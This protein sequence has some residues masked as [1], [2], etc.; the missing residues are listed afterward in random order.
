MDHQRGYHD[1]DA[2]AKLTTPETLDEHG[3]W[4]AVDA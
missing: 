1:L 2:K 4:D 3:S